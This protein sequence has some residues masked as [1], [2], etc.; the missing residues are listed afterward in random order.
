[1]N[2]EMWLAAPTQRNVAQ[3]SQDGIEI[4]GPGSGEQACGETGDGRML[5]PLQIVAELKRFFSTGLSTEG[6]EAT[7]STAVQ[8]RIQALIRQE[9]RM[10]DR[11]RRPHLDRRR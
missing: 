10:N 9:D 11:N 8:T 5:E 4:L 6:G 3:L 7:S 1:M 2:R